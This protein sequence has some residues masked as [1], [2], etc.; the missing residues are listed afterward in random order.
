[1]KEK[2]KDSRLDGEINI[3]LSN[4]KGYWNTDKRS[5]VN[6]IISICEDFRHN[7][8]VMT[9]R[10]LYYQLVSKD[11][12]PNHITV[13]KKIGKIKDDLVYAGMIDWNTFEDRGRVPHRAYFEDDVSGA[14]QRTVD[15]YKLD[16]QDGQPKHIE[17]WTE[18]D[19][20][21][22]ILKKVTVPYTVRL[23]VNKGYSSSTAM[24]QAY[25][26]FL[27]SLEYNQK[28]V[29]LYFGDHD[30]SGLDMIRDIYDR[31]MFMFTNGERFE[32]YR[33]AERIEEWWTSN[34]YT[35][36]DV[37]DSNEKYDRVPQLMD[38]ESEKLE[39]LFDEGKRTMFIEDNNL[40]EVKQIGL[41]MEQID[42]FN[43]PPNPAKL[44]D[45]RS[46]WYIEKY[47]QVSWEVDAIHPDTMRT[48]VKDQILANMDMGVY[49]A[50][51]RAE[52]EDIQKI[53]KI[54]QDLDE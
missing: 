39:R 21:S 27:K 54:I 35:V 9:L 8:D 53:T 38:K 1:M 52:K 42:E 22:G 5:L 28:V 23:V 44:T 34:G 37:A 7:G 10:Q 25:D 32:S 43:P 47:G 40:F 45:P 19:A 29:I 17:V 11:L 46:K 20:I 48:I 30:P 36:Y 13:Y 24:Y 31:I 26:R 51:L 14:L 3:F 2:F 49:K 33:I 6:H 18:K 16:K 50:V 15:F 12:I 41:T 4:D